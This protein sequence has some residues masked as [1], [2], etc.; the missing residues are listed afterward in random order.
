MYGFYKIVCACA[1]WTIFPDKT[2][3]QKKRIGSV[4]TDAYVVA[5]F[6]FSHG[7]MPTKLCFERNAVLTILNT[8]CLKYVFTIILSAML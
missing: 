1:V 5:T 6:H 2:S 3:L 4:Y 8:G 7:N